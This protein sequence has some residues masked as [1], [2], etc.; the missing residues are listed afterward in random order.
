MPK[1]TR[2]L[3]VVLGDQLDAASSALDGFEP[4]SDGLWMAEVPD[5]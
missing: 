4:A 3:V 1:T 2:H 5:E